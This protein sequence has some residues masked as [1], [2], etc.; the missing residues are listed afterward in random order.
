[1]DI[2]VANMCRLSWGLG[3]NE[4][5]WRRRLFAWEKQLWGECCTVVANIMLQVDTSDE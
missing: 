2:S 1:K 4:W 5:L 3:G